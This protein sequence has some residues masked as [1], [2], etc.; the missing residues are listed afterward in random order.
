MPPEPPTRSD[1]ERPAPRRT[2]Q[3][4]APVQRGPSVAARVFEGRP[5]RIAMAMLA[6]LTLVVTG[7]AWRSIDSLR[8]S[9]ATIGGLGLGGG[10][11]GALDILLVVGGI[12]RKS[13]LQVVGQSDVRACF[14]IQFAVNASRRD[15]RLIMAM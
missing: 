6:A 11:D 8:A 15:M 9:L 10:E 12:N 1:R 14:E 13:F 7:F 5:L 2:R 4:T 3:Q